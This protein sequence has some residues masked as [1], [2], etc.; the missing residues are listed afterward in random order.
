[1]RIHRSSQTGSLSRSARFA[2]CST[3]TIVSR[4]STSSDPTATA[5]RST[6]RRSSWTSRCFCTRR[7]PG[8]SLRSD[9]RAADAEEWLAQA[10]SVYAGDVLEED[11]Y[12]EWA[13]SLREEARAMYITVTHALAG[14]ASKS[15]REEDALRYYLRVLSRDSYDEGAHLGVVS[16]L[17]RLGRRGEARRSYRAYVAR[18]EEI[19]AA[20]AAFPGATA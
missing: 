17:E 11:P 3:L 20:P 18:M 15:G 6:S 8:S 13:V 9:V 2:P 12:S 4:Q 1:M 5:S 14:N 10:E 19:G 7:R 16:T